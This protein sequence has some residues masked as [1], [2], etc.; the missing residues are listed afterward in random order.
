MERTHKC[1]ELRREHIGGQV[2][3]CAWVAKRRDL[4]GMIFL[5]LRDRWGLV[6]VVFYP[7]SPG[8]AFAD[9]VRSEYVVQIRGT[10]KARDEGNANADMAT[11]EIEVVGEQM[12]ILN[13]A[14]LPPFY[15][16]DEV[17]VDENLRLRYRYLDL[18]RP[19]MQS[20]LI[21]RSKAAS[22]FRNFLAAHDF[23][24]VETPILTKS[25]PEGA[26]DFLVPSRVSPGKFYALPQS[27]QL[28][29]QLLMVA[30]LE[31]YYQLAR[32]FRDEDL[33]ADRQ[34]E[35]TQGDIEV[36][37]MDQDE[38]FAL[39]EELMGQLFSEL[40]GIQLPPAFP[41]IPWKTAMEKYGSDKPDLRFGM[42]IAD[43]SV[44]AAASEFKVF[45]GA[46]KAGGSVRGIKVP[47]IF[48]RKELDQ[49]TEQVKAF[50]AQGLAWMAIEDEGVRSPIAKFFSPEQI[51]QLTG[52][53][54][55]KP[56]EMLLFVADKDTFGVV[57]PALGAIRAQLGRQLKLVS[58]ADFKPCW[59]VD[60]PL[61]EYDTEEER[62]VAAHHPFTA[63]VP[64]DV[65]K[66]AS[67]PGS[68]RAQ[69]YDL[70]LNGWEIAGGS[71]RIHTAEVQQAMFK[72]IGIDPE[73]AQRQFGFLLEALAAGAPPHRGIAFG[74]D[75]LVAIIAG[76]SSIRNV[77]AFPK[78]NSALDP[79]TEAPSVVDEGQLAELGLILRPR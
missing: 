12:E 2:A 14:T 76:E 30:G 65:P 40:K 74:F 8:Y 57:L 58:D 6:Q 1:G 38:F 41:R 73:Q 26:R 53:F 50:G 22:I 18:R 4:G 52:E 56:G 55:A 75:R 45:T 37:F 46:I 36:S 17:K 70:V 66:L 54:A 23:V 25:T 69:A 51:E 64:E 60:F 68:A 42:E 11:G 63:P 13:T 61:F 35:F 21:L 27:P 5:D 28:L 9:K 16:T 34:L 7:D 15:I 78:S 59:V 20:N 71:V 67:D 32:C 10:V 19:V 44:I 33:R 29:K 72:A 47:A 77:I 39:I 62:F 49:L 3:L 24:E 43:I 31:R 48:S 79:M